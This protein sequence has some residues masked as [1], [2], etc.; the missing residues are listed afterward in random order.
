MSQGF[1]SAIKIAAASPFGVVAFIGLL[2]AW[3]CVKIAQYRLKRISK[4]IM[5][6][7]EQDRAT[8]L[9]REYSTFP[10]TGLSAEQWIR[11]RQ[12]QYRFYAI[13]AAIVAVTLIVVTALWSPKQPRRISGLA[14]TAGHQSPA[15]TGDGNQVTIGQPNSSSEEKPPDK[16]TKP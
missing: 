12:Y 5:A 9:A 6:V 14:H 1:F 16:S 11:S 13:L 7:P 15:I 4:I 10:R 8:L 2:V 3:A